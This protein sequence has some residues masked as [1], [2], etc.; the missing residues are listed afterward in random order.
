MPVPTTATL[1]L[2]T[3][4][5]IG[6]Y[7]FAFKLHVQSGFNGTGFSH[8][9]VRDDAGTPI[10]EIFQ[11]WDLSLRDQWVHADV[12]AGAPV[13]AGFISVT[14]GARDAVAGAAFITD[15]V[16]SY[17][18]EAAFPNMIPELA[19]R[20]ITGENGYTNV[21]GLLDGVTGFQLDSRP[22]VVNVNTHIV[23]RWFPDPMQVEVVLEL[24][25]GRFVD[26]C[27]TRLYFDDIDFAE[28]W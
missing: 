24:D 3:G 28:N 1:V 6:W 16:V 8:I 22:W 27:G 21:A 25:L 18:D 9:A 19:N 10:N 14:F 5:G 12:V 4:H 20:R 26:I 2:S 17:R 15:I 13:P 7:Q 23:K 11:E